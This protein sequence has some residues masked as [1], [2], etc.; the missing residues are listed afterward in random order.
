MSACIWLGSG[1]QIAAAVVLLANT[2]RELY[3]FLAADPAESTA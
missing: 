3:A 1:E 2:R